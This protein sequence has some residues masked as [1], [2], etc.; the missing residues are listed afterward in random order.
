MDDALLRKLTGTAQ[1]D[2]QRAAVGSL[3][4]TFG[5]LY[6]GFLESGIP[7]VLAA[8]MTRDWF[9]QQMRKMLWPDAPP[10]EDGAH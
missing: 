7:E 5:L 10:P 4:A 9:H 2:Q 3:A 6:T 1:T 8:D